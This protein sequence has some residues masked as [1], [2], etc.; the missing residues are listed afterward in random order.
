[1][2]RW[3][4]LPALAAAAGAFNLEPRLAVV[5]R[6]RPGSYFGYSVAQHQMFGDRDD[7]HHIC[8]FENSSQEQLKYL[9]AV[10]QKR[11]PT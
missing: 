2:R 7:G 11:F 4:W 10:A 3:W 6:G 9:Y 1:M 5:K 8:D